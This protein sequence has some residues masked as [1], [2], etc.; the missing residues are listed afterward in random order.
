MRSKMG[1]NTPRSRVAS[2]DEQEALKVRAKVLALHRLGVE[3]ATMPIGRF[4]RS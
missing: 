4:C 2:F 1:R 3:E